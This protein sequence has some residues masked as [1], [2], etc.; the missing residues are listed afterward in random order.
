MNEA[1]HRGHPILLPTCTV[2][3]GSLPFSCGLMV[4]LSGLMRLL[5]LPDLV[6]VVVP[7]TGEVANLTL[8]TASLS[9]RQVQVRVHLR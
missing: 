9:R 6:S 1:V 3:T 5:L 2:S 4:V 7:V 8:G